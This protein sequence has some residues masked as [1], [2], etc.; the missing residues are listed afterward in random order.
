[1]FTEPH[2]NFCVSEAIVL[3]LLIY[4]EA[5]DLF[6]SQHYAYPPISARFRKNRENDQLPCALAGIG[7]HQPA[8]H[9]LVEPGRRALQL[10]IRQGRHAGG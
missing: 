1:M 7:G 5:S 10:P 3:E 9:F 8:D 6:Q 2:R 4:I